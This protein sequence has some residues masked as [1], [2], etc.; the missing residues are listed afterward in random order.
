[1]DQRIIHWSLKAFES[2]EKFH[3]SLELWCI[4]TDTTIVPSLMTEDE[5][6]WGYDPSIC[7]S[8]GA[9]YRGKTKYN[10]I[11]VW[12]YELDLSDPINVKKCFCRDEDTCPPKGT[13]DLFRCSGVRIHFDWN[14]LFE[15]T[16][17]CFS[18]SL[19]C[20]LGADDCVSTTFLQ[21]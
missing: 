21:G 12:I 20:S 3:W 2:V 7:R 1:M 8:I 16:F 11:P 19:S 13:F 9:S 15:N 6:I 17:D 4:G 14:T 10:G 18:H 5:G